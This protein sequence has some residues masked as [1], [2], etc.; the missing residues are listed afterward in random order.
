MA[1][2]L[3]ASLQAEGVAT[4][5]SFDGPY[6]YAVQVVGS[7]ER[8]TSKTD[9][10]KLLRKVRRHA[11]GDL[12]DPLKPEHPRVARVRLGAVRGPNREPSQAGPE[13]AKSHHRDDAHHNDDARAEAKPT[14]E[15][16]PTTEAVVVAPKQKQRPA[17]RKP[18]R[19]ASEPASQLTAIETPPVADEKRVKPRTASTGRARDRQTPAVADEKS[20]KRLAGQRAGR[21]QKPSHQETRARG[22]RSTPTGA[23]SAP[24]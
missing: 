6:G 9:G 19:S 23:T 17:D 15:A 5:L 3:V 24:V 12:A 11:A 8:A 14:A 4:I 7:S 1:N 18:P 13:I 21:S 10:T 20:A 16:A 22:R 2:E